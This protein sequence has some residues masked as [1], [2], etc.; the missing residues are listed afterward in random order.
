MPLKEEH[1][2]PQALTSIAEQIHVRSSWKV[3]LWPRQSKSRLDGRV[4]RRVR[5]LP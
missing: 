5:H 3:G 2:V 4:A 1:E